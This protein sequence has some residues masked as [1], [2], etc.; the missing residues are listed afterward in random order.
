MRTAVVQG[1]DKITARVWR[2]EIGVGEVRRFT[3]HLT[4][5]QTGAGVE[6]DRVSSGEAMA[7]MPGGIQ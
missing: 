5:A 1:L 2:L 4:M 6:I 7:Q 3:G